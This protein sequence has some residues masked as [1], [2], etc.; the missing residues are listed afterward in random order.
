VLIKASLSNAIVYHM[1]MFLPPKTTIAKME[2]IRRFFWHGGKLK[3]KYHLVKWNKIRKAKKKGGLGIKD[4][5]RM[6]ISLLCKWWWGLENSEGLWQDIVTIKYV[7][8]SPICLIPIK[9][10]DLPPLWKDLMKVRHI[11]LRGRGYKVNNG[12]SVSFWQDVWLEEK[13]LCIIYPVLFDL[14]LH[15]NCSVAEVAA[16]EWVIGFKIRLQLILRDQ[17]YQLTA[18]LNLVSLSD[19]NDN[20]IWKWNASKSNM[21]MNSYLGRNLEAHIKECGKLKSVRKL[22]FLCG[23]WSRKLY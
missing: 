21:S 23:L 17:W 13:P 9:L 12:K 4:L 5:R 10:N 2:K 18:K 20:A 16:N 8:D 19:E 14:C 1:S 7:K 11:Y 3:R 15:R 22:R 6:N